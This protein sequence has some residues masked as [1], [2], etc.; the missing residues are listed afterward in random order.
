MKNQTYSLIILIGIFLLSSCQ[1]KIEKFESDY[2]SFKDNNKSE[3]TEKYTTF[4]TFE[5][6]LKTKVD[7]KVISDYKEKTFNNVN[8]DIDV[9]SGNTIIVTQETYNDLN[10]TKNARNIFNSTTKFAYAIKRLVNNEEDR[11]FFLK[12][13]RKDGYNFDPSMGALYQYNNF[14]NYSKN[15]LNLE[16]IL[17]VSPTYVYYPELQSDNRFVPGNYKGIISLYD[18]KSKEQIDVFKF[19][20]VN[21]EFVNQ[22]GSDY[23]SLYSDFNNEISNSIITTMKK[24]YNIN[25]KLRINLQFVKY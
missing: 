16:Y 12:D 6:K 15:F 21:S 14:V 13:I 4:L 3:L 19:S 10:E 18:I 5:N 2:L 7:K 20:A 23:N 11:L 8:I 25:N 17:V 22:G 1:S 9:F 24:R